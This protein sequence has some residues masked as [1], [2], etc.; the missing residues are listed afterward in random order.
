M[1]L[2]CAVAVGAALIP[3]TAPKSPY[4]FSAYDYEILN[5]PPPSGGYDELSARIGRDTPVLY[6]TFGNFNYLMGNPTTCRYPSPQWLQRASR[7]PRVRTYPSY[8]D[9]LR[10][11]TDDQRAK[12]LVWTPA[13]FSLA[14][15]SPEL[16]S[17]IASRF[18]CSPAA[19]VPAPRGVVVCPARTPS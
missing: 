14:K 18:D 11:L 6:L 7:Y 4:A 9:N 12:Y 17:L 8:A 1:L 5:E 10:C 2:V 3:A 13:W 19:Q 15:A 16:R